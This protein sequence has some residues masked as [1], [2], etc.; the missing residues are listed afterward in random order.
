MKEV[1]LEI[2]GMHCVMCAAA[3]QRA[4]K[5]ID[6]V[7][8]ADVSYA[9]ESAHILYDEE[10]TNLK[11]ISKTV[12]K[13]GYSVVEDKAEYHEREFKILLITFIISAV[14]SL[15]F[16]TAMILMAAAPDSGLLH[17]LHNGWFQLVLATLVQ[18]GIGWRFFRGG[19]DSIRSG[20]ANMDVLVSM[21]TLSAYIYSVF[22]VVSGGKTFYFE[23]SVMVITLVLLGKLFESKAKSRANSAMESLMQLQ[24]KKATVLRDGKE[25]LLDSGRIIAGDT[26]VVRPGE[27]VA[28]DG[29]ITQGSSA[30]DESM[31]TGESIPVTKGEG[32]SV[33]AGTVNRQGAF[34]FRA[35]EVGKGTMLSSIVKMVRSAQQSK[36]AI[37]KLVDKVAAVFVPTIFGIAVVTF[38]VVLFTTNRMPEAVS[39]GVAVLVIACP[40]ALGLATPTALMVGTG[41]AAK[42]GILIKDADALQLA[43]KITTVILDKTGTITQGE[44]QV[45]DFKVL[46]GREQELLKWAAAVEKPSEHPV[47]QAVYRYAAER[48]GSV[49]EAEHFEAQVGSGVSAVIQDRE[50]Y[51]GKYKSEDAVCLEKE[52]KTAIVLVVDSVP[53]A[54]FA[55]ADRVKEDSAEA[56]RRM[57]ESGIEVHMVTG[58]NE[59]TARAIADQ[60]GIRNVIA[61]V[62]PGQKKDRVEDLKQ[63]GRVVA[64]VGDGA[65]DAPALATADIGMALGTGTDVAANA[66][67]MVLMSGSLSDVPAAIDLSQAIMRKIRQ[68]LFW[69]V[70]YNCIGVPL[71]A[72]GVLHPVIAGTCMAFSSVSVVTNSLL[73]KRKKVI[74]HTPG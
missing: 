1:D 73:L 12:K 14:L 24:P 59:T 52:G 69:A 66:G 68:N 6:G 21:G 23:A 56:V 53:S 74:G 34:R 10:K 31:L 50:V 13:A 4:V 15:P 55:V 5:K 8:D 43:G 42:N 45:T 62:L 65:N 61:G 9:S 41:L 3:V 19:W 29:I 51:L 72:F 71:A 2:G 63:K 58:D 37:Q 26:V 36:P 48:A 11:A 27:G 57:M 16:F 47:G 35:T 30:I 7:G 46:V 18:F 33:F 22:S 70:I 32:D 40:C 39:H 67:S 25:I 64:M 60:V 17:R 49:P 44:P 28:V 38:L 20:S 54:V